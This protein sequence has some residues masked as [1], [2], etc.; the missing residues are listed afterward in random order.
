MMCILDYIF[1][2]LL[3]GL[4]DTDDILEH[5]SGAYMILTFQFRT[6]SSRF[7]TSSMFGT[8]AP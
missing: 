1:C 4:Y 3:G 8:I 6:M 7:Q 2:T 5:I